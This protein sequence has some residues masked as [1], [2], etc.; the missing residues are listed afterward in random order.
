MSATTNNTASYPFHSQITHQQRLECFCH[1]CIN[2]NKPSYSAT[3]PGNVR[4]YIG[5][6]FKVGQYL[7]RQIIHALDRIG[8]EY[9]STKSLVL[10]ATLTCFYRIIYHR[11]IHQLFIKD[12]FSKNYSFLDLICGANTFF[13]Q[14]V[15]QK[16]FTNCY[17]YDPYDSPE[18]FGNST[19]LQQNPFN[20]IWF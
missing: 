8:L 16:G 1:Y 13:L 10:D 9:Y 20:Y 6:L 7:N 17:G 19:V 14:Y 5:E 4:D 12:G 15:Q 18:S 2:P 3:F 11:K